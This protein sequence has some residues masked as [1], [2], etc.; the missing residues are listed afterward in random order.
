[1]G[2]EI[3]SEA[4]NIAT[5]AAGGPASLAT[6]GA[7]KVKSE[8]STNALESLASQATEAIGDG[9]D[10]LLDH[11][12]DEIGETVNAIAKAIGL[13]DF[14]SAH[15]LDF[16]EGYYV[17][18]PMVNET[19]P[20]GSISKN[21][22]SCSNKTAMHEFNPKDTLAEEMKKKTDGRIDLTDIHWPEEI[23]DGLA[24]LKIAQKAV[25][26][27]Y[28]LSIGLIFFATLGAVAGLFTNGRTGPLVNGLIAGL[29]FLSI[30]IASGLV[31]MIAVKATQVINKYGDDISIRA[32]KGNKFLALTWSATALVFI[33]GV[34]WFVEF[35]RAWRGRSSR[36]T[37][38]HEP[39]YGSE[40][41]YY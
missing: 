13:H 1:M 11:I 5:K 40:N 32:T 21:V 23:D 36:I 9:A 35:I 20:K 15:I 30:L 16:C 4:A 6:A 3:T 38:S 34:V 25:F 26:V 41:R 7:T 8:D 27:L 2:N 14:Y 12:E 29:A 24:A 22:T 10:D 28:C 33:S 39:K 17:P 31:T 18:G 19:V 37:S